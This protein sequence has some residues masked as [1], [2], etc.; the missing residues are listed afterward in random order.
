MKQLPGKGHKY[1]Q[2]I[3]DEFLCSAPGDLFNIIVD[4]S[5]YVMLKINDHAYV[6]KVHLLFLLFHIMKCSYQK[7]HQNIEWR[8]KPLMQHLFIY[9][10]KGI[11][12]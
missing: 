12:V 7:R 11:K 8:I 2:Q 5:A 4:I 9:S 1:L 6:T 10:V 3:A